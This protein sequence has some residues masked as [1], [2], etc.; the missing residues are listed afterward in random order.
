MPNLNS[1]ILPGAGHG[2]IIERPE[3]VSRLIAPFFEKTAS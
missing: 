2:L 3:E 1:K